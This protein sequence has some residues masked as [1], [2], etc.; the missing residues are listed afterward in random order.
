M[1]VRF[2]TKRDFG[3]PKKELETRHEYHA[4]FGQPVEPDPELPTVVSHVME[5]FCELSAKRQSG[6][7]GPST[8]SFSDIK[9]W[10]EL[11][12][13]DVDPREMNMI[14]A[15]DSAWLSAM[16]DEARQD[17]LRHEGMAQARRGLR[18]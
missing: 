2:Y 18:G 3:H 16:A 11:T 1:Q 9:A 12:G 4:R 5:W 15:M 17:R 7:G 8:L 6:V 10:M 14:L 13:T